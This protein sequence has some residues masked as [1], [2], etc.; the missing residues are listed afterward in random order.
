MKVKRRLFVT[1]RP[2]DEFKN[3]SARITDF[4][5]VWSEGEFRTVLV[6]DSLKDAKS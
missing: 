3:L 4:A 6:I 1:T 5:T 2:E